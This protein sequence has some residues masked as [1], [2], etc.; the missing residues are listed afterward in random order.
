[1][2]SPSD[3]NSNTGPRIQVV[4]YCLYLKQAEVM[5]STAASHKQQVQSLHTCG[6]NKGPQKPSAQLIQY[7]LYSSKCYNWQTTILNHHR[8][9]RHM[10]KYI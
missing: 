4:K 8:K 6:Q 9:V 5:P 1:M 7:F 10:A 3:V 2:L